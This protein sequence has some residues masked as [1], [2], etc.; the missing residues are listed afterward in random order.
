MGKIQKFMQNKFSKVFIRISG[1][2]KNHLC[3][4]CSPRNV[5]N[6]CTKFTGFGVDIN[7]TFSTPGNNEKHFVPRKALQS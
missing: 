2:Y 1:T 3:H 7:K 6:N 5:Q 4:A